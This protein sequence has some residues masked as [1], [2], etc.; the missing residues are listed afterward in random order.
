[1]PFRHDQ[2]LNEAGMPELT[3][4]PWT[5]LIQEFNISSLPYFQNL[6]PELFISLVY[7]ALSLYRERGSNECKQSRVKI[8]R[9]IGIEWHIH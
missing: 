2:W 6:V 8:N 7:I 5:N 9:A 4:C 3:A 1:M